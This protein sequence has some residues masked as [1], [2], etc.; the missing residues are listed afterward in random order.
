VTGGNARSDFPT[1]TQYTDEQ[2]KMMRILTPTGYPFVTEE[3]AA[4]ECFEFCGSGRVH[5]PD[6][7]FGPPGKLLSVYIDGSIHDKW[8][9]RRKDG[10]AD[11]HISRMQGFLPPMRVTNE[12]VNR[13]ASGILMEMVKRVYGSSV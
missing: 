2:I 5:I 9:Q 7:R 6:I 4:V 10:I 11:D 3:A 1:Q 13:D 8:R 12:R